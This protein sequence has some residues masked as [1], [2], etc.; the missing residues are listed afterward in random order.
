MTR[1]GTLYFRF[2]VPLLVSAHKILMEVDSSNVPMGPFVM[3]PDSGWLGNITGGSKC[4]GSFE[5]IYRST[6]VNANLSTCCGF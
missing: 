4:S 3:E 5:Q 1:T 2:L 6:R